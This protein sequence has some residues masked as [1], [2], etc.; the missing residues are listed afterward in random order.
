MYSSPAEA[1]KQVHED[2][3]Y[4]TAK[5][6]DSSF[7]LSFALIA[8]NWAA[9]GSVQ[10]IMSNNWAKASLI[11]VILL[12]GVNLIGAYVLGQMHSRRLNYANDDPVRW[13]DEY[14]RCSGRNPRPFTGAIVDLGL[15]L[16]R[17]KTFLPLASGACFLIALIFA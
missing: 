13:V 4:W 2:Y 8:G 17:A 7:Q 6:T 10:K 12:L 11:L 3:L 9:F 1:Q 16:R 5:L 15:L 14:K